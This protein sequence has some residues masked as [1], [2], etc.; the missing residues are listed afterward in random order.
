MRFLLTIFLIILFTT[1]AYA[2][3]VTESLDKAKDLYN[4]GKYYKAVTELNFAIG[5]IQDK[6]LEKFKSLLPEPPA[7]WKADQVEGSRAPGQLMGGGITVARNYTSS[8]GQK[9]RIE[10]ITDSPLLSSIM[11][12]LSNPMMMG[13]AGTRLVSIN[14]E[15][16]IEEWNPQD[17]S[18]KIQIVLQNRMLI[19][20]S[21]N[22]LKSKNVLYDFAKN[23]DFTKI[24]KA[25]EE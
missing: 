24:K 5:L 25:M 16:G 20:V 15:K 7:G 12:F 6:Q 17:K 4:Q 9:I 14:G 21:G 1:P 19:S 22:N 10:M 13:G 23:L 3:N 11:M 2:D 8:D 18:G